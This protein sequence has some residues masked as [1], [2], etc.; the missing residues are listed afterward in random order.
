MTLSRIMLD[1]FTTFT[2]MDVELSPGI[3]VFIGANGTG[4]THLLKVAYSA[5]DVSRTRT[6]L[7]EKLVA[8]FMP[9]EGRLARLAHRRATSTN[10]SLEVRRKGAKI[11]LTFSNHS[12]GPDSGKVSG[13]GKWAGAPIE[14]AYIPVKEMLANA[15]GFRS[16]YAARQVHF[17]EIYA[18]IIDRAYLPIL[19]GPP[20]A[21]RKKLL[22]SL[23]K[24][25]EGKVVV[26]G[27]TFFLR[28]KH[29]KLEFS[30]L[31][32]GMSKLAL[33]WLLIQNGTLQGGSVLFWDEPEANLN[34]KVMGALVEILLALRRLGVQIFLATHD[35]VLLKE[36]DLQTKEGDGLRFHALY[37]D[38]EGVVRHSATPSLAALDHNAIADTFASLYD[39]E[40]RRS[41]ED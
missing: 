2:S 23:Q 9:Y 17:E 34:P 29:G 3:N 12:K 27:E 6:N 5:C 13:A 28:N 37:R 1:G 30:L 38:S 7:A 40:I 4:K 33:L 24:A 41:L 19:R 21:T 39:R 32:E 16:L 18:D 35:Y 10:A 31:A 11:G 26:E 20:D 36:F 22:T 25:I 14:C 8:T 15:P